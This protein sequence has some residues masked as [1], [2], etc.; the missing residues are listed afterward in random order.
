MSA[1]PATP[2]RSAADG[3]LAPAAQDKG[4]ASRTSRPTETGGEET[5]PNKNESRHLMMEA[6]AYAV[7]WG[8]VGLRRRHGTEG[9]GGR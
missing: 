6:A 5:S 3:E 8:T 7:G 2:R 1:R 9:R 4:G